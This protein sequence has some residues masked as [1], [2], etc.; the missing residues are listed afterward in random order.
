MTNTSSGRWVMNN[1]LFMLLTE[2]CNKLDY[3]VGLIK[4]TLCSLLCNLFCPAR[5]V[6][7]IELYYSGSTQISVLAIYPPFRAGF[8][9]F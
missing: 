5:F 2:T 9:G 1:G 4:D 3:T 6:V 7:C 8:S